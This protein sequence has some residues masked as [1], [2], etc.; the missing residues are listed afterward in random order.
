MQDRPNV[1]RIILSSQISCRLIHVGCSPAV[2]VG[3]RRDDSLPPEKVRID[4]TWDQFA[5]NL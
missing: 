1:K 2:T 4:A 3:I 5:A